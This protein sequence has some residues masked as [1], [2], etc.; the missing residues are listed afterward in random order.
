ME[1]KEDGEESQYKVCEIKLV[2]KMGSC[3]SITQQNNEE[4][5]GAQY[6]VIH[7]LCLCVRKLVFIHQLPVHYCLLW[8]C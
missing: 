2:T 1:K 8:G 5:C 3:K 7:F 6:R 4:K